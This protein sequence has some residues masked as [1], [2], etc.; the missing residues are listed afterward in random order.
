MVT[1]RSV[2]DIILNMIDLLRLS[3]PDADTKPG[4]VIRDL[5][6]DAPSSQMGLLYDELSKVSTQQS[7]LLVTGSDLDKLAKNFG[8]VR[9]SASAANGIA[10]LTFNSLQGT[11]A[12]NKGDLVTASNGFSF[13]VVNGISINPAQSNFYKSVATKFTNDLSFVG[14]QDQFAVEVTVQS[15]TVGVAGNIG[16]YSLNRTTIPGISNVTNV[17]A[18]TGGNNQEDDATFRNRILAIFSGSSVG[19]ALGY[20]NTALAVTGV[21]DAYVIGPGDPLMTRDGTVTSTDSQGNITILSEGSGGKVDIA[22]LGTNLTQNIDSF[23]YRDLSNK[24]DPTDPKNIFVLGQ[25]VADAGKTI[26]RR[27]LDDFAN[28]VLPEQPVDDLLQVTGSISGTNFQPKTVDA[29]GRVSGNFELIKDTS[30]FGGSPFGTDS[31]HW[32]SNQITGFQEDRIKGKFNGQDPTTFPDV[33]EIPQ[34]QQNVSIT[35]ENSTVLSSNRTLIQLLHTPATNVTRVFNVN[36][37]ERYTVINQNPNGTGSINSSGIIQIS[38]NTLPSSSDVLQVDYTWIV[39]FDQYS[40]YDGRSMNTNLRPVT[41]S[42]DWGYSNLIRSELVSFTLNSS[43][44][45]FVGNTIHPISSIISSNIFTQVNGVVSNVT[46]GVFAGRLSVVISNLLVSTNAVNNIYFENTY[47]ELYNTA[48]NNGFFSNATIV[49]G[50]TLQYV[51][52][53]ILPTDTIAQ[54]GDNVTV[55]LN[56]TDTFNVINSTGSFT[57]NQITIPAA[58]LSTITTAT[59]IILNV[60]YIASIQNILT[61]GISSL[62]ISRI[63]NGFLLNSAV[64]FTN[65]NITNTIRKDF[66]SVNINLSNQFYVEIQLSSQDVSLVISQVVAVIRISDSLEL[67][68]NDNVGTIAINNSTNNYQLILSGYNS[69]NLGDK[70]LILYYSN[71]I[72]RFQPFTFQN[73]IIE[74]DFDFL[75][76]DVVSNNFIVGIHNFISESNINFQIFEPNTN[77]ILTSAS[78]GYLTSNLPPSSAVF[79]SSS[80]NFGNILNGAGQNINI[81]SAKIRIINAHNRNNSNVYDIASYNTTN[82]T[83]TIANNFSKITNKQ[84]SIIRISDGK[85]LWSDSGT[86]DTIND[87]LLFPATS[88]ANTNDKVLILF[89]KFN[90]LKQAPTRLS[91]NLSDQVI[92]TGVL[93]INGDTLTEAID[94]IFTATSTGLKQNL[95]DAFKQASGLNSNVMIP[96]NVK[97]AKIA[98]LEKVTTVSITSDEVLTVQAI[99]DVSGSTIKDNSYFS[100]EFISN[101]TLENFDFILPSTIN[102]TQPV[103][104]PTIGDRIRITFYYA[105]TNDLEN[106][107]FTRNGTLYTNKLFANI[108]KIY[109][110]SGFNSS[111]SSKITINNFNQPITG[112]RYKATYNYLAPKPNERIT[113]ISNFNKLISDVS[114]S[115]ENSRPINADILVKEAIQLLIDV[116]INIVISSQVTT[117]SSLILQNVKNSIIAAINATSLGTTLDSS[118]LINTSFSV[119]GVSGARIIYFNKTGQSGQVVSI[120]AHNNEYLVA[121]NI[122]INQET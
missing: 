96:G 69:P 94:I 40:D 35:N 21:R 3:Q 52:T 28:G 115:I 43:S 31:F 60:I 5:V 38:G 92:N 34:V 16:K 17:Q 57:N 32:I 81:I 68:N 8:L 82:N 120:T 36:T 46:S 88:A 10:L 23:I 93:S 104:I 50:I 106:V 70:V 19:T 4:T 37:G 122:I 74:R 109:V 102:N 67:W 77:I 110:A 72:A 100:N 75:Q 39:N 2:N 78:D 114:F 29:F 121:N 45:F 54:N 56:S 112:S 95:T 6:I 64:G 84:I 66:Q 33:L 42:V 98:K 20:K 101:F 62:P 12:V 107:S 14:I 58:N 13:A 117:S 15:T 22:V 59:N 87:R 51:T 111:Q 71:D 55:I 89:Y 116:T 65:N 27:R 118:S 80:T 44:N 99:Y 73:S 7:L 25:I 53:I 49:V 26:N 119:S 85:D 83:I 108:N 79:G 24:N 41:D 9:K 91:V 113:I 30:V 90:N 48:Q 11:I 103:N 18:F 1:I 97:L 47:T 105:T 86:I 63:S 61:T 76:F